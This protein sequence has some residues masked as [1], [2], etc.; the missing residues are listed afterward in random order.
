MAQVVG[1]FVGE[2]WIAF[3]V[4]WGGNEER[5]TGLSVSVSQ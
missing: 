5:M 3:L 4:P 2:T 1:S